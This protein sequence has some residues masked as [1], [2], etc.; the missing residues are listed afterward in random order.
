MQAE[1]LHKQWLRLAT[2][3]SNGSVNLEALG[4]KV[5]RQYQESMTAMRDRVAAS[6]SNYDLHGMAVGVVI[7]WMVILYFLLL[8]LIASAIFTLKFFLAAS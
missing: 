1:E 8:A 2:S 4:L 7:L 6:L 5:L 3:T